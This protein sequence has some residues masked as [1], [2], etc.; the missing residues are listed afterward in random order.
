MHKTLLALAVAFGL[1]ASFGFANAERPNLV[2]CGEVL[3][4]NTHYSVS[5][6][7]D[8][9]TRV[10]PVVTTVSITLVNELTGEIP[11]EIP[12]TLQP[13]VSCVKSSVGL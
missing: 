10:Q 13:F 5:M 7:S 2:D 11:Q 8:W 6:H 3:P 9:D 12:E 4:E 1:S